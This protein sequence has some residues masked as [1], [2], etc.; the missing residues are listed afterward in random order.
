MKTVDIR[1]GE[2]EER[3][4]VIKTKP[5]PKLEKLVLNKN[6]TRIKFSGSAENLPLISEPIV[7]AEKKSLMPKTVRK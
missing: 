2:R 3:K 1:L 4:R 7:A 6:S 5:K